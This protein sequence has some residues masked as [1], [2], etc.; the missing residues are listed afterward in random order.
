MVP[1]KKYQSNL[2]Y[3]SGIQ[4]YLY[5]QPLMKMATIMQKHTSHTPLN[6][7]NHHRD[8][9]DHTFS[10]FVSPNNDTLYSFAW[11]DLTN[12]PIELSI[13]AIKNRYFTFQF[14]DMYT[15]VYGYIGARMENKNGGTF[16]IIGTDYKGSIPKNRDVIK[17]PHN[18]TWVIGRTLIDGPKDLNAVHDL[19]DQ[20][21]LKPYKK[22]EK[23]TPTYLPYLSESEYKDPKKYFSN[24][25][26]LMKMYPPLPEDRALLPQLEQV[27]I[28]YK[29]GTMK[30]SNSATMDGLKRAVMDAEE[31]ILNSRNDVGHLVNNWTIHYENIGEFN[32][33]Y[34]FR[35]ITAQFG[36]G[37]NLTQEAMYPRALLD[38]KGRPLMGENKYVLHFEKDELP[39]VNSFWSLSMYGANQ[40]FVRNPIDRFSIGDR[41]EGLTYNEDGS[42]D[43]YIQGSSPVRKESNWLPSPTSEKFNVVLRMYLPKQEVTNGTY[44]LPGIKKVNEC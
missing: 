31:I 20:Y 43:I 19:Q 8:L 12:G 32:E 23:K 33:H 25:A 17:S 6:K 1:V 35:A 40:L 2:A 42:L 41:T 28:D 7:F 44:K 9:V 34:L 13:P 36:I 38:S 39:K 11:L 14:L 15:N 37:A 30:D 4:A 18:M 16:L 24:V 5:S 22:N 21:L 3:S 29:N 26:H 27:G 10:E